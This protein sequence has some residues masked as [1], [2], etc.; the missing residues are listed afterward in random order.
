V[1]TLP[2]DTRIAAASAGPSCSI[3]F[4]E[5]EASR[6]EPKPPTV[7][8]GVARDTFSQRETCAEQRQGL[9]RL[10]LAWAQHGTAAHVEARRDRP[11]EAGRA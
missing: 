8:E 10:D 2:I 5:I 9:G 4:R 1:V 11:V 7:A 6:D 3:H